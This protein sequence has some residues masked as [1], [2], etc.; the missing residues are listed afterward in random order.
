MRVQNQ[1]GQGAVFVVDLPVV[2]APE[3]V[4]AVP[5]LEARLTLS[6]K[7]IL[8]VDDEPAI[9]EML[10][11]ML[12]VDG[13][14][15]EIAANGVVALDK[16]R[17]QA[18]DL[19]LSDLRMPEL[20]GP[21]LYQELERHHPGLCRRI[22]FLTGDALGPETRAFLERIAAPTVSKPFAWEEVRR[23]VQRVLRAGRE[24]QE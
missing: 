20:D 18:Y 23:V 19:V 5:A 21:G 9:A 24:G 13:H 7:A 6:G 12:S 15:V 3:A 22:I 2:T 1:P 4:P 10:A 8:V 14:H 16:L 11:E 17:G